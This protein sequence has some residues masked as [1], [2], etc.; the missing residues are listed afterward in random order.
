M[1]KPV[2][3]AS[4]VLCGF[5]CWAGL[6][7][8]RSQ[9]GRWRFAHRAVRRFARR[10]G[11]GLEIEGDLEWPQFS[12]VVIV[13]NHSSFVDSI[14]LVGSFPE[15]VY[16]VA[17]SEFSGRPFVGS[18]LTRLGVEFVHRDAPMQATRDT[19]QLLRRLR[20]GDRLVIF[21]EGSLGERH[22]LRKFQ[23]GA[24]YLSARTASPIVPIGIVGS[25]T[26]LPPGRHLPTRGKIEVHVGTPVIPIG[27]RPRDLGWLSEQTR[28]QLLQ[29]SRLPDLGD[30]SVQ[31]RQAAE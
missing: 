10:V 3:G 12:S 7:V 2:V 19:R 9:D 17:A 27:T 8:I 18:V 28:A 5:G 23:P 29:L 13:A 11:V 1:F 30:G 24:F 22:G 6:R 20:D 15:P 4:A 14:A 31:T 16:F 26:V 25:D 21:P